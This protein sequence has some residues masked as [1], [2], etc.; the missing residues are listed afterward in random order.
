M[1]LAQCQVYQFATGIKQCRY[2]FISERFDDELMSKEKPY[3]IEGFQHTILSHCA[4][5]ALNTNT[6]DRTP[7]TE[8][9]ERRKIKCARL[10]RRANCAAPIVD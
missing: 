6:F 1:N 4:N 5:C 3:R 8:E 9:E 10:S 2:H 7:R